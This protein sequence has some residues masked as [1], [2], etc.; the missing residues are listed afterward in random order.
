MNDLLLE[1]NESI[2]NF[3]TICACRQSKAIFRIESYSTSRME[4][5]TVT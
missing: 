3:A 4:S 5:Y 1:M 2:Q